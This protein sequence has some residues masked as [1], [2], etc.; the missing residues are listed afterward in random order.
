MKQTGENIWWIHNTNIFEGNV[1]LTGITCRPFKA[2]SKAE[3]TTVGATATVVKL[4]VGR[5]CVRC[6]E[7]I[8]TV[9]GCTAV[10]GLPETETR[11]DFKLSGATCKQPK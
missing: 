9:E 8:A 7:V 6:S 4:A 5:G 11:L 10:M 1:P 3:S 2:A